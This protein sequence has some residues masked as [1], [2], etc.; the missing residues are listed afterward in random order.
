MPGSKYSGA[1]L[2]G[3]SGG[4]CGDAQSGCAGLYGECQAIATADELAVWLLDI[5]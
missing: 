2:A 1:Y 5:L 4:H 3:M